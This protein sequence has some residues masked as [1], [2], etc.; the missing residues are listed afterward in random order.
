[1][2]QNLGSLLGTRILKALGNGTQSKVDLYQN[3]GRASFLHIPMVLIV[4]S[5]IVR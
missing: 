2:I 1:M 3:Y 4:L 5:A